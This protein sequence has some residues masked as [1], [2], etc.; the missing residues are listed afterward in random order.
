[1]AAPKSKAGKEARRDLPASQQTSEP[2]RSEE[3]SEAGFGK[4]ELEVIVL[5]LAEAVIPGIQ[6][7]S[8]SE[9]F[10]ALL[11]AEPLRRAAAVDD[12][13]AIHLFLHST[14]ADPAAAWESL[15]LREPASGPHPSNQFLHS[16]IVL[17][18]SYAGSAP[19]AS[20]PHEA[21]RAELA[22]A[23]GEGEGVASPRRRRSALELASD[24]LES[25]AAWLKTPNPQLG[26]RAPIDLIGTDE[27]FRVYNLLNAVDQ[28]LF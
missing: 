21:E 7:R 23:E 26:D 6:G 20:S 15:G 4:R 8:R 22:T 17:Y 2:T 28:G 10:D 11:A 25:P 24:V 18:R 27:E 9:F 14:L 1:M 12:V 3:E 16:L 5:K 13:H 19:R